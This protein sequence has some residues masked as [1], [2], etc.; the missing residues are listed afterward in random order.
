MDGVW[1]CPKVRKGK[2]DE[3]WREKKDREEG[4]AVDCGL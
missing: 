1:W 3:R 2:E 4:C